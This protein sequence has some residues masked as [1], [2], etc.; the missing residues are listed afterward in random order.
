MTIRWRLHWR[1]RTRLFLTHW[2]NWIMIDQTIVI[3]FH[4]YTRRKKLSECLRSSL[5][6][7]GT[8]PNAI[9]YVLKNGKNFSRKNFQTPVFRLTDS[10][11]NEKLFFQIFFL[12]VIFVL[13]NNF[14]LV[15]MVISTSSGQKKRWHIEQKK[16]ENI[17]QYIYDIIL[18]D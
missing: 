11:I 2:H 1:L 13:V 10:Q 5:V 3:N 16:L 12:Q 14:T 6:F 17:I 15:K 9:L 8:I 18:T 7:L 4:I